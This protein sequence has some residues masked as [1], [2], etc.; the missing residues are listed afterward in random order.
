MS[1]VDGVVEEEKNDWRNYGGTLR[2]KEKK[3]ER[4]ETATATA[5]EEISGSCPQDFIERIIER[6][7][8]N[9]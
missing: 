7:S 5:T 1:I 3:K 9:S 2:Q 6:I 4:E 8:I